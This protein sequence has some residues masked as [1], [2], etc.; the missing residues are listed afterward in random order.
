M[1]KHE[2]NKII[3]GLILIASLI[4][5]GVSLFLTNTKEN[6]WEKLSGKL[7]ISSQVTNCEMEV[8]FLDVGGADCAYI[9]CRDYNILIDAAD[10]E[11]TEPVCEY[12][13]NHNVKKLDLVVMSHPHR[14]HI[15]QMKSVIDN[16]KIDKFIQS[17][18]PDD[19]LPTSVTYENM[20]KA[21]VDKKVNTQT[22]AAGDK[23]NLGDLK[24]K[25]L[26]PVKS[27]E[28][29]NNCSLVVK[30]VY[31]DV[32]FL[33]T[34]DAEK[35]EENTMLKSGENLHA[36][37][38]KVGHHGSTT[39]TTPNFLK[40]VSPKYAVISSENKPNKNS[41][42][43]RLEETCVGVYK[44][45]EKGNIIFLTDGKNIDIKTEK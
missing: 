30:V 11:P 21:L 29:I 19:V 12:L 4:F 27:S 28:N 41:V 3:K 6:Y 5:L 1:K 20:L 9:R 22:L 14:D 13:S 10:K 23:F 16:F 35:F 25:V 31:K 8:H 2:K 42:I 18:I 15:G 24:F 37:V 44:T 40:S 7:N 45:Y 38:L 39:S 36:T 43:K 26:G 34:G 17:D 33:F 32:S